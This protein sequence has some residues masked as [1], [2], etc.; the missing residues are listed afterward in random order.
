MAKPEWDAAGLY[1]YICEENNRCP[2]GQVR[3]QVTVHPKALLVTAGF[4]AIVMLAL[5]GRTSGAT[6]AL[7]IAGT[8]AAVILEALTWCGAV[9][10]NWRRRRT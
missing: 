6:A 2:G 4:A 1:E 3:G 5:E 7:A 8:A 9:P 10:L